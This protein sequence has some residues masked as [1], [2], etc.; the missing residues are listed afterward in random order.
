MT[1]D[2]VAASINQLRRDLLRARKDI[3]RLQA[4]VEF[5]PPAP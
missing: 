2:P 1:F 5:T 3:A 4:G